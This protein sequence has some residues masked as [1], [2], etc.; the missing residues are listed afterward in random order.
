[1]LN[2]LFVVHLEN[3][4]C[5]TCTV[6]AGVGARIPV[7][8]DGSDI[9]SAPYQLVMRLLII[10]LSC[11]RA[12]TEKDSVANDLQQKNSRLQHIYNYYVS[13]NNDAIQWFSY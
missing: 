10:F 7:C 4:S 6:G 13:T 5:L 3:E 9:S 1:M 8:A 11:Y 12:I 2:Y